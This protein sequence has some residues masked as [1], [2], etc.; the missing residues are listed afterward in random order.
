MRQVKILN[1]LSLLLHRKMFSIN[2]I[3][4]ALISRYFEFHKLSNATKTQIFLLICLIEK[5]KT[6]DARKILDIL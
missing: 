4:V 3:V 1:F 2:F 5:K 6:H